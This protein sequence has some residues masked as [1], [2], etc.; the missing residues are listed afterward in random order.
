MT[1]NTAQTGSV[2]VLA[3]PAHSF[4]QY[5]YTALQKSGFLQ[6]ATAGTIFISAAVV[7]IYVLLFVA[8]YCQAQAMEMTGASK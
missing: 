7:G 6:C 4:S 5:C 3:A 2:A 1:K 8:K